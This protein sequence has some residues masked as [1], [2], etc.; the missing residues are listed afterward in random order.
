MLFQAV[1]KFLSRLNCLDQNFSYKGKGLLVGYF[2]LGIPTTSFATYNYISAQAFV[3]RIVYIKKVL[4][5]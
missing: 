5:T 4:N 3:I 1:M 2:C